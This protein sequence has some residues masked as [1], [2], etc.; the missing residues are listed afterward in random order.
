LLQILIGLLAQASGF[1]GDGN[2][3]TQTF[4]QNAVIIRKGPGLI[5]VDVQDAQYP[6]ALSI[7][8]P[9]ARQ[10]SPLQDDGDGQLAFGLRKKR[11]I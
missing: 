10:A 7:T 11:V 9:V 2:L 4:E 6:S 5:A 3:P 8:R 1:N